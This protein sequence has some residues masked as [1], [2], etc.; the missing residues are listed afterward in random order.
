VPTPISFFDFKDISTNWQLFRGLE[1][2]PEIRVLDR[3]GV[4]VFFDEIICVI[5]SARLHACGPSAALVGARIC[6]A[7]TL[8]ADEAG[9]DQAA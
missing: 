3:Q 7:P 5:G 9:D 2:Q 1:R 8:L 4:E 6:R